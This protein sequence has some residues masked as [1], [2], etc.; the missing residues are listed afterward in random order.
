MDTT[1]VQ[2]SCSSG[3][4]YLNS[5]G[6]QIFFLSFFFFFCLDTKWKSSFIAERKT[7]PTTPASVMQ[8]KLILK[9]L[10]QINLTQ[11]HLSFHCRE[12][13]KSNHT[14]QGHANLFIFIYFLFTLD[15]NESHLSLQREKQTQPHQP[16][17]CNLC[18]YHCWLIQCHP[19][20]T[21]CFDTSKFLKHIFVFAFIFLF[22]CFFTQIEKHSSVSKGKKTVSKIHQ[23]LT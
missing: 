9:I 2:T 17:S 19:R 6:V 22:F 16:V 12:R 8:W 15:T 14:C 11:G 18:K 5:S 21:A 23:G 4:R 7:N 1:R 13:N 20:V 10:M 3:S